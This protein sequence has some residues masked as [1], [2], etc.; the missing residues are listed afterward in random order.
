MS[1]EIFGK[2]RTYIEGTLTDDEIDKLWQ[3]INE[4]KNILYMDLEKPKEEKLR[5]FEQQINIMRNIIDD[6]RFRR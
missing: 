1:E 4:L 2:K 6:I 5:E 3:P